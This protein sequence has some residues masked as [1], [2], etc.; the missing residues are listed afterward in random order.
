MDL[1]PT[2]G[3]DSF[4]VQQ[5]SYVFPDTKKLVLFQYTVCY[6]EL[7]QGK[8]HNLTLSTLSLIPMVACGKGRQ[9]NCWGLQPG[10]SPFPEVWGRE[11]LGSWGAG[12]PEALRRVHK[13][14]SVAGSWR[15]LLSAKELKTLAALFF[16]S[17]LV[18]VCLYCDLSLC[19]DAA[20]KKAQNQL[21]IWEVTGQQSGVEEAV[22]GKSKRRCSRQQ[23]SVISLS[24][25]QIAELSA[26]FSDLF[27]SWAVNHSS[28]RLGRWHQL[29]F[30]CR[31]PAKTDAGRGGRKEFGVFSLQ[32]QLHSPWSW[33]VCFPCAVCLSTANAVSFSQ[34]SESSELESTLCCLLLGP[35]ILWELAFWP[36][37]CSKYFC[38]LCPSCL[39]LFCFV[40]I[41]SKYV[42]INSLCRIQTK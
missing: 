36:N 18:S 29:D 40:I 26:C 25:P 24:C 34:V 41:K 19:P 10:S 4:G 9:F 2:V 23:F 35:W 3:P 1:Y 12:G 30:L 7:R 20:H 21:G 42:S 15:A 27:L 5:Y 39:F 32:R 13:V 11:N 28:A 17:V 6:L 31:M 8:L 14:C 37:I 22:T 38:S 16:T 33:C